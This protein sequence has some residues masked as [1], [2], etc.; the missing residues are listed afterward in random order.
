M[1]RIKGL[2]MREFR[3]DVNESDGVRVDFSGGWL[4]VRASG[5]EPLIRITCEH[6]NKSELEKVFSK[7]ERIVKEG[8][9]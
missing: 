8:L 5:T 4:L 1:E 6:R 3:G 7:A 2:I 9:Q